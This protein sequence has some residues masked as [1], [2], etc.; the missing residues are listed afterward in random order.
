[1]SAPE[2]YVTMKYAALVLGVS[3]GLVEMLL[4]DN[5]LNSRRVGQIEY[6]DAMDV[7]QYRNTFRGL[8]RD[9]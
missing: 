8:G 4:D 9:T 1:M 6:I 3:V 5:I 7:A 2:G